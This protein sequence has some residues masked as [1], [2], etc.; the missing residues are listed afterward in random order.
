LTENEAINYGINRVQNTAAAT[1][2]LH[3]S[4]QRAESGVF[5]IKERLTDFV[6]KEGRT[7]VQRLGK[8]IKT[9]GEKREITQKGIITNQT[10]ARFRRGRR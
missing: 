10:R 3:Q 8:R 2:Q 1:F 9:S 5:N 7:F 6:R 4:S